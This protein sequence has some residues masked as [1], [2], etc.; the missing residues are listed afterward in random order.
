MN[1]EDR[2]TRQIFWILRI[3]VAM[4]FIGHGA[5]GVFHLAP[6]WTNYFAVVGIPKAPALALMPLVGA[7]DITM[8][9][10][11]LFYP[12][13][14]IILWMAVWGPVDP[15]SFGRWR[16]S[17][18]GRP[19]SAPATMGRRSPSS[20]SPGEGAGGPGSR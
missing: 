20:S 2:T 13:R 9:L 18:C 7:F 1:P 4:E 14:A 19:S 6:S 11:V 16:A 10:L 12:V 5:L 15:R 17:R 3:G 8:G